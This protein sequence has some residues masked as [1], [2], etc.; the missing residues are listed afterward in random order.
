MSAKE[1]IAT[2]RPKPTKKTFAT[3]HTKPWRSGEDFCGIVFEKY[4]NPR[5]MS[6]MIV[7]GFLYEHHTYAYL[8]AVQSDTC[9]IC[10]LLEW[11]QHAEQTT[12]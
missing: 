2:L 1:T 4:R 10:S 6:H 9:D 8:Y 3:L 5:D 12:R 7:S 11:N